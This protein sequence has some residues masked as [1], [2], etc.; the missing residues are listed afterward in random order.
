MY[1]FNGSRS[2]TPGST[3]TCT[4]STLWSGHTPVTNLMGFSTALRL[5]STQG[6][7][8]FIHFLKNSTLTLKPVHGLA[9][10]TIIYISIRG[11]SLLR[12]LLA[13]TNHTIYRL[14]SKRQVAKVKS[15]FYTTVNTQLGKQKQTVGNIPQFGQVSETV[16]NPRCSANTPSSPFVPERLINQP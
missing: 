14:W 10:L 5:C 8:F 9:S 11:Q 16:P 15:A 4:D 1:V 12:M 7:A 3:H 6:Q 2:A 13:R